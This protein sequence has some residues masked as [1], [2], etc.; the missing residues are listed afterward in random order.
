MLQRKRPQLCSSGWKSLSPE[1]A[2]SLVCQGHSASSCPALFLSLGE[3]I[4]S[5][6]LAQ[7]A[8]DAAAT[9]PQPA[10]HKQ[11]WLWQ[12]ESKSSWGVAKVLGAMLGDLVV[13]L[14][15]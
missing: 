8:L 5:Y 10:G 6:T 14:V 7:S 11:G 15:M 4:F 13:I 2:S 3:L 9:V 1:G 12:S